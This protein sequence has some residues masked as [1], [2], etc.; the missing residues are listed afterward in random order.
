MALK[1]GLFGCSRVISIQ[2]RILTSVLFLFT[3]TAGC[4]AAEGTGKMSQEGKDEQKSP[5]SITLVR[6]NENQGRE[7]L[8][9]FVFGGYRSGSRAPRGIEP[10]LV[11]RFII[12]KL[13]ADSPPDAYAKT[14]K[15]LRFYERNECL[16]HLRKVHTG[17]EKTTADVIRSAYVSQAVGEVGTEQEIKEVAQYFDANLAGHAQAIEA[18]EVLLETLVVLSPSATADGLSARIAQEV[19]ARKAGEKESEEGMRAYYEVLSI[20]RLKVPQALA[21]AEAKSKVM[22]MEGAEQR[23]ELLDIYMGMSNVSDDLMMT[24]AG[25]MLRREAMEK[26]PEPIYEA[27]AKEIAKADS[28]KVGK[29][30]LADTL[31]SRAAQAILYLQGKLT[32]TERDLYE[33]TELGA[34]S[35]LW[36]DLR[37]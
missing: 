18:A 16:P 33:K 34:I 31:V 5:I 32:K 35:F 28:Q 3:L 27:F 30:P 22:A 9:N 14:V 17:E 19:E 2:S 36:D 7:V 6:H 12:E 13:K 4:A 8:S 24:W 20:Q 11:S 15:V 25:R 1:E 10:E 37:E 29:D 26:S 21:A 23:S